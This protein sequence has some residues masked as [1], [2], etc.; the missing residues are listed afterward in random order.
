MQG[1][2]TFSY[3]KPLDKRS[4]IYFNQAQSNMRNEDEDSENKDVFDIPGRG[5]ISVIPLREN[6]KYTYEVNFYSSE[7]R[8]SWTYNPIEDGKFTSAQYLG[9]NDSIAIIE[10]LT[11]EKLMS[12]EMESTLLGINLTTGRKAFEMRT[13]DGKHQ[14]YPMNI[15]MLQSKGNS[16]VMGPYYEGTDRV[17]QDKSAGFGIWVINNAGKIVSSKYISWSKDISK[18]LKTDQRGRVEDLGYVYFHNII[19]TEDGKVFAI[20]EGYKKVASAAGI[21]T[22]ALGVLAGG[23]GRGMSTSKMK[24]TD[25]VLMQLNSDH[26][27][28]NAVIYDKYNN[29][30]EMPSGAEFNS[31]HTLA[32][33]LK[34]WGSFDYS[35]TQLGKNR[36]SF[37]TSYTDYEK[38]KDYK[39]LTFNTISYYDGKLST[40]KINLKTTASRLVILPAKPGSVLV[41]EYFKKAKRLDLRMEKMN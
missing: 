4:E 20:G 1:K 25:M 11:K 18:F 28:E 27:L 39:G 32:L 16:L 12:K 35:F 31:P 30:V 34:S 41:A 36:S 7:K 23:Y 14:L 21:A 5:F 38:G 33:L 40:D 8:K 10:I 3:S 24:V 29:N 6:R 22:T 19:Q 2:K 17:L 9:S 13:Q 26:A 37:M 15:S